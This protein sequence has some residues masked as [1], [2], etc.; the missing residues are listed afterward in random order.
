MTTDTVAQI[1]ECLNIQD[2]IAPYMKLKRAGKSLVG[3]CP[4][5]KEKTPSFHVS[6]E[7]GTWHCFGC[8]EG[9][10]GF[11][12]I[13]KIEG[14]DFKGA[15]KMLA[16]KA[17]VTIEY[18]GGG[19]RED[20]SKKDRLRALMSRASEWYAGKLLGSP[21]QTYARVRGLSGDTIATWRLGYAPDEWRTLLEALTAEGFTIPELIAAGLIKE[22]DGKPGTYYDRFR[23]RLVFPIRDAVGRVVAFTGRTLSSDDPAKYLNSPE[24]DLYHKSEI[25][26]GMDFAKD[27]IRM[28]KFTM[29][30][31]GQIDVL[32]AHQAGFGNAVALSGTALSPM[33][34]ALMKRY[35]DN[36]M[37]I[38]DAD[39]AGRTATA[40]SAALALSVGLR[41][42]AVQ[43][44]TGK[45]P[46]DLIS[47]DPKEFAK[48][49]V[50]AKPIVDFFLAE[51][52]EKES[53]SHRLLRAVEN[54]V[55]PL[56][57]A[58][59][60]PMEREHFIQA[61]AR[62]LSISGEAVRESLARLSKYS[63]VS[64][65]SSVGEAVAPPARSPRELRKERL[66]AIIRAYP[67]TS[68]AKRV[69]AEYCRITEAHELPQDVLPESALFNA[70]QI[71]GEEPQ[72]GAADELLHAFEEAVIREAYQVT[73]TNLRRAEAAGDVAA[74]NRAQAACAALSTRLAALGD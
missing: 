24:T 44:P 42:K 3:L 66:L 51:L 14:V 73:V 56:I 22:A 32:H 55:L 31:E 48:R 18:S 27:A 39:M 67:D 46:A 20:T 50:A 58:M 68:L 54:I 40:R 23:N 38:L 74:I 61:T 30:V 35:S 15:L 53:D 7:R 43:L 9:G 12:F 70:E 47:E 36:L 71:F 17:G 62:S 37:L 34:L 60:S 6:P 4:F 65:N 11:S 64:N 57:A 28:R 69:K 52:A 21:A 59:P 8:G 5:H 72:E 10:D 13:E 19:N 2:I 63:V 25:L 1:K 26:F 45:D 16:E 49:V 41:V 33:H 29:L